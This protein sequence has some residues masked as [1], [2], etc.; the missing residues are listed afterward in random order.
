[1]LFSLT[2]IFPGFPPP[3]PMP[4]GPP[5]PSKGGVDDPPLDPTGLGNRKDEVLEGPNIFNNQLGHMGQSVF[6]FVFLHPWYSSDKENSLLFFLKGG[7]NK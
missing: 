3:G 7:E 5:P 1:M 6:C 4:L 2:T